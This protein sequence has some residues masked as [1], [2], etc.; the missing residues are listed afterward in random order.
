MYMY[1][2]DYSPHLPTEEEFR[3]LTVQLGPTFTIYMYFSDDSN[4]TILDYSITVYI[5]MLARSDIYMYR[6]GKPSGNPSVHIYTC[7]HESNTQHRTLSNGKDQP[8]F[9]SIQFGL[10]R[11]FALS[12]VEVEV[13]N[14]L[15]G[16]GVETSWLSFFWLLLQ[17]PLPYFGQSGFE[18]GFALL[19][20]FLTLLSLG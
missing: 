2:Y 4:Q 7:T 15:N 14:T 10:L 13:R 6:S 19:L 20:E 18:E 11:T 16:S 12:L 9:I 17:F 3:L 1:M 8:T 5:L